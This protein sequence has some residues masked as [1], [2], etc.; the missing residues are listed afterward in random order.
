MSETVGVIES[1]RVVERVLDRDTGELLDLSP[2]G[3]CRQCARE[4][5]TCCQ[6]EYGVTVT[7]HDVR[8]LWLHTGRRP[9]EFCHIATIEDDELVEGLHID[10]HF[11]KLFLGRRR[12][13]QTIQ[14]GLDCEFLGPEGCRVFEHRPRLCH[15]H[16]FWFGFKK[17][18]VGFFYDSIDERPDADETDCLVVKKLWPNLG[19]GLKSVGE[20]EQSF[21]QHAELMR[22]EIDWQARRVRTLLSRVKP[23]DLTIEL[24]EPLIED[25]PLLEV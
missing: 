6:P 18:K 1:I 15:F 11:K 8:R 4:G 24:L 16:P 19:L 7:F 20:D 21:R 12:L 3:L 2:G 25:A 17:G 23:K 10:P 5:Y 14:H 13:L 9:R 22:Q